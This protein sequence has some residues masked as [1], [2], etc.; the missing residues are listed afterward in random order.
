MQGFNTVNPATFD[1]SHLYKGSQE[2]RTKSAHAS[3]LHELI[4]SSPYILL[5][6][7]LAEHFLLHRGYK[8]YS[9][10]RQRAAA[11]ARHT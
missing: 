11:T 6:L 2:Q 3:N 9:S 7:N 5:M 8:P 1:I 10:E 4:F